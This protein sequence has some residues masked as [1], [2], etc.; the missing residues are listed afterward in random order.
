MFDHW[1]Q[2]FLVVYRVQFCVYLASLLCYK[3]EGNFNLPSQSL[4]FKR[5]VKVEFTSLVDK[6]L[7]LRMKDAGF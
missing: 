4:F 2:G 5:F 3:F 6:P 7:L 1:V